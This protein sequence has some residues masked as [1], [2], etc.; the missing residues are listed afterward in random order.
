LKIDEIITFLTIVEEG[1]IS[2]AAQKLYIGQST[3]SHRIRM[4][5]EELNTSLILRSKGQH[6][7]VLTAAG[8]RFI[9]IAHQWL[10]L[11][12]DT[13][14]LDGG[15]CRQRVSIGSV[16]LV[17]NYTFVPLY[18]SIIE[19]H[20]ELCL[21]IRTHHSGEIHSLLSNHQ[22]D[23]GFV[24]SRVNT[25]D[26]HSRPIYR[27]LMYL[28]CN[29]QSPYHDGIHPSQLDSTREI[30]LNWGND[31]LLWHNSYWPDNLYRVKVNTGSMIENYLD[32]SPDGWSIAPMSLVSAMRRNSNIVHYKLSPAP[33]PQICYQLTPRFPKPSSEKAVLTFLK[34][35]DAYIDA[36]DSI[37][38]YQEWMQPHNI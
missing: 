22:I 15:S 24:F 26:L 9:P 17:N 34:A 18:K 14:A 25:P 10:S 3:V 11:W 33:P 12:R 16:D 28:V 7:V 13:L 21:D 6:T 1:N 19:A 27:E 32:D 5:E 20:P 31:F 36:S 2:A 4:L 23:V 38:T 29:K 35:M 8:E 37:C 30:Y